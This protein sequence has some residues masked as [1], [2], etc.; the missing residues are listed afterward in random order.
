MKR[1][2]RPK[3]TARSPEEMLMALDQLDQTLEVMS[4][5]VNRLRHE[6]QQPPI[7]VPVPTIVSDGALH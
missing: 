7:D 4:L 3:N 2:S 6:L 5:V 1:A